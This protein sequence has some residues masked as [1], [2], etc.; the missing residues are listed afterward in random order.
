MTTLSYLKTRTSAHFCSACGLILL[1]L[2][3]SVGLGRH[4]LEPALASTSTGVNVTDRVAVVFSGLRLNRATGTF[5]SIA[6]LTNHSTGPVLAP[7][8][9][10]FT[11][12]TPP[13]VTLANTAGTTAEG[14]PYLTVSV[15]NDRLEAG[16]TA[17]VTLRFANPSRVTFTFTHQVFGALPNT[18]PV[19]N[20]GQNQT[21]ALNTPVTLNGGASTDADS[22]PLT[23]H[24]SLTK[25]TGSGATLSNPDTVNPTFQVD[26]P[27]QYV[28]TLIV[29]D[30]KVDSDPATVTLSTLNSAPIAR[31][32]QDQ[33]V[34]LGSLVTLHGSGSS[35]PDNDPLTYQWSLTPPA[36]STAV[37]DNSFIVE[38]HFTADKPGQYTGQLIVNDGHASSAPDTVIVSTLNSKPVANAGPDQTVTLGSPVTLD[39]RQSSDADKNT[40]LSYQWSFTTSP[41]DVPT[42]TDPQ[43]ATPSFTPTQ[44]GLYIVQLI[45]NDGQVNSDP[46]TVQI[47]VKAST[48]VDSDNDGLT[49]EEELAL[50]TDPHNPDTDGDG[51]KDGEEVHIYHTNPLNPDSDGDTFKD[52]EE[53]SGG[54]N[55]NDG[56]DTP[57]GKIP[58]DPASVAPALD[59][60]VATTTYAATTFIYSGANPIQTGVANGT[61]EEKRVAVIRGRVLAPGGSPLPGVTITILN[62]PEFGK[63]LSRAD[64]AFDLTVNGGG[65]L[66]VNYERT[67]YLPAQRQVQTPWQDYVNADD[68]TLLQRDGNYTVIDLTSSVPIQV[69]R[70]SRMSDKDGERQATLLIPNGTTALVYN[71]D[72]TTR[73]VSKLTL[74]TTEYTVGDHGPDRMPAPLPLATAYTYAVEL[75]AEEAGKKVEGKDVLFNQ[76]VYFYLDNFL[77]IPVGALVPSGYLDRDRAAWLPSDDGRVIKIVSVSQGL[78][79]L[80]TN[81]DGVVD[82]GSGLGISEAE[83]RTLADL[84][85]PDKTVWRIPLQHLST[86]D[87]NFGASRPAGARDC[88]SDCKPIKQP[89]EDCTNTQHSSIIE[90][91]NQTLREEIKLVGTPSV[92][93]YASDRVSGRTDLNSLS[94]M[95]SGKTLPPGLQNIHVEVSVAGRTFYDVLPAIAEQKYTFN[96]DGKDAYGRKVSGTQPARVRVGYDY[97]YVAAYSTVVGGTSNQRTFGA[98]AGTPLAGTIGR[99]RYMQWSS[100]LTQ[101]IGNWDAKALGVAGWS[102]SPHHAYDPVGKI[103]YRGNGT[104]LSTDSL[105]DTFQRIAGQ[106]NQ[107][108]YS[109]DGGPALKALLSSPQLRTVGPDGSLYF[110]DANCRIRRIDPKGIITTVAGNGSCGCPVSGTSALASPLSGQDGVA[111]APDGTLYLNSL[112]WYCGALYR[113]DTDGIIK[114]S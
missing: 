95:V 98:Y 58:P 107:Q 66:T 24:W 97:G 108:G 90:C 11:T 27:G 57:A 85:G 63:T 54:G 5:D 94:L 26:L 15:A 67:S 64:G 96:W 84:Y 103:L 29:N 38:P 3:F 47:D 19:A 105:P 56:V 60:T 37:L 80:D 102:L 40:T 75:A 112:Y 111:S 113:V 79:L 21:V 9:L 70:G 73:P 39:G 65:P 1:F 74:S 43:A 81:G 114:N 99:I 25:P 7:L 28:A 17:T 18:P 48:P 32:G 77:N 16:A 41:G 49:D 76:P 34:T 4:G 88:G 106:W 71:S 23:Y 51:L 72:G 110:Q 2:L 93:T 68:V 55:P 62:H 33:S 42:L 52:G 12:I 109:G 91:E 36:G 8:R 20:A 13:S 87:F 101:P 35:D 61:I 92:L 86:Y 82:D 45:V 22:D 46:D 53:V 69:A 30:G 31:A 89:Q 44:T 104:R 83:R 6:T 50:G 10:V 78:A 14:L 100:Y 59:P